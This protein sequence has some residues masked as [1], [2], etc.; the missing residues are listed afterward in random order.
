MTD[1]TT[2]S[3]SELQGIA[4]EWTGRHDV[5]NE[6]REEIAGLKAELAKFKPCTECEDI[7]EIARF[8]DCPLGTSEVYHKEGE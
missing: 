8:S 1:P 5:E 4:P 7:L 3:A 2:P 6:L